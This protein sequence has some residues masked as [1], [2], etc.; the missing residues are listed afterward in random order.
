MNILIFYTG[1][2]VPNIGGVQN[3]AFSISN[4]LNSKGN[5]V[6]F[7]SF[8]KIVQNNPNYFFLPNKEKIKSKLNIEYTLD[9]VNKYSI[10]VILNLD[11]LNTNVLNLFLKIKGIIK[12][13]N[14]IHNTFLPQN[15]IFNKYFKY[16]FKSYYLFVFYVLKQTY[17][18]KLDLCSDKI[19][20]FSKSNLDDLKY[21]KKDKKFISKVHFIPNPINLPMGKNDVLKENQLLYVGR[22][23]D[24]QK[25]ITYILTL[26]SMLSYKYHNWKLLILGSGIDQDKLI[27]FSKKLDLKNIYFLG[28]LYPYQYYEKSKFLIL[29][30]RF[31]GWPMVIPEAMSYGCVPCVLNSFTS[32]NDMI[33]DNFNGYIFND[34]DLR[35][36]VKIL[37]NILSNKN[38][39]QVSQNCINTSNKFSI[40]QIGLQWSE[41]L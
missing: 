31:E 28:N 37:E 40:N 26:W 36:N 39:P 41:I 34:I 1:P 14:V 29:T 19:I 27:K 7:L 5:N 12:I 15:T 33:I 32:L 10:D 16:Y 4:Y 3:V 25:N 24:N 30:S 2:I 11:G 21:F 8:E 35:K 18:Y 22:L 9:L 20:L 38:F 6:Y 13:F 17:Y 23:D